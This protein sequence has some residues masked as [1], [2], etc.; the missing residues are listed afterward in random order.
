MSKKF[1]A[2]MASR[3]K[4]RKACALLVDAYCQDPEDVDWSDVQAAL[5][6][7]LQALGLPPDFPEVENKRRDHPPPWTEQDHTC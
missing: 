3:N 1:W 4:A 2:A 5:S 7:A 6:V